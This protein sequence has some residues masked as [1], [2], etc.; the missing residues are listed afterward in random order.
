MSKR[1]TDTDKYKK[2]FMRGLPGAYKLLWDYLYHDCNHAGI[3]IIDFEIAQIY[4]GHDMPVNKAEALE[5]FNAEEVKIIELNNGKKWFIPSFVEFQYGKLNPSNKAHASVISI[6]EKEEVVIERGLFK[7]LV[8]TLQGAKD[9]DMDKDMDKE[10]EG[11]VKGRNKKFIKPKIEEVRSYCLERKNVV[12]PETFFDFYES[13]G[14]LVGKAPMKN[15]KAAI[16]TWEK[17]PDN[18]TDKKQK[19][20]GEW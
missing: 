7:P 13:K 20:P 3:W 6:L 2:H 8:R 10:K 17:N 11:I 19:E 18:K 1:F 15:W 14:W 4:L 5:L 9:K 12:D 16:R